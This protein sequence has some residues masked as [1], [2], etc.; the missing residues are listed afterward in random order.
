MELKQR[1]LAEGKEQYVLMNNNWTLIDER[2]ATHCAESPERKV[3]VLCMY[4]CMFGCIS[5]SAL[6]NVCMY[7]CRHVLICERGNKLKVFALEMTADPQHKGMYLL[8]YIHTYICT[9]IHK[10][11][12]T[13]IWYLPYLNR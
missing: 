1:I 2:Y 8:T 11:I 6:N 5:L 7:V 10:Y 13:Y 3:G 9:Y 12:H 4:V